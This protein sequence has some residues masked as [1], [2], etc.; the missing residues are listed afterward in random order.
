MPIQAHIAEAVEKTEPLTSTMPHPAGE[1]SKLQ[2]PP[3]SL[4][5]EHG[6][7]TFGVFPKLIVLVCETLKSFLS[8]H[9]F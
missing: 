8:L 9:S 7:A 1:Q 5:W 3:F 2:A 6:L 4:S